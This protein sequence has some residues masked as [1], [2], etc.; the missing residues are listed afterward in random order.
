MPP[1]TAKWA[2]FA[3]HWDNLRWNFAPNQGYQWLKELVG[4]KDY[5]VLT[6]NECFVRET[7][8]RLDSHQS[9]R[10]RSSRR[11]ESR[12]V[13]RGLASSG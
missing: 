9:I 7:G 5:F 10:A 1:E 2:F 11:L 12:C 8:W 13:G 4:D 6:S 3:K